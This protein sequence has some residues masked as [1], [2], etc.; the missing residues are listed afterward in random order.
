ML[1]TCFTSAQSVLYMTESEWPLDPCVWYGAPCLLHKPYLLAASALQP[2]LHS[3]TPAYCQQECVMGQYSGISI[4]LL[5][6][7]IVKAVLL[8]KQMLRNHLRFIFDVHVYFDLFASAPY[9]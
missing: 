2:A 6:S 4:D 3:L 7:C 8:S 1:K 5:R 9:V